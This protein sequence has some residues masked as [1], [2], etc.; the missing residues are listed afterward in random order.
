[1]RIERVELLG[2]RSFRDLQ[3]FDFS[4]HPG[5]VKLSG[6]NDD[7]PALGANGAGK[8]SFWEGVFWVLTGRTSTGLKGPEVCTWNQG[9]GIY[10]LVRISGKTLV[11]TWGTK[12]TLVLDGEEGVAQEAV[13]AWLGLT[14]EQ[15]LH[16]A[17]MAQHA[18]AFL[19]LSAAEKT[20]L[21]ASVLQLDAW[22]ELSEKARAA[23]GAVRQDRE[24]VEHAISRAEGRLRELQSTDYEALV[25]EWRNK[26][27]AVIE[28]CEEQVRRRAAAMRDAEAR[29]ARKPWED[30]DLSKDL[31]VATDAQRKQGDVHAEAVGRLAGLQEKKRLMQRGG[32][33]PTCARPLDGHE[34]RRREP[35]PTLERDIEDAEAEAARARRRFDDAR[36][37]V[38][39]LVNR[40]YALSQLKSDLKREVDDARERHAEALD[41]LSAARSE[42]SPYADL[43]ARQATQLLEVRAQ[44]ASL[45]DELELLRTHE[46]RVELWVSGFKD[47]RLFLV[48]EALAQLELEVNACLQQLGLCGWEVKFAPDRETKAGATR[49]GFSVLITSPSNPRPVPWSVW[50]GGEAQR[51]RVATAMGL[52]NLISAYTGFSPFVEVWDEPSTGMSAEGIQGLLQAFADRARLFK[53]QVWVVDHRALESGVFSQT[54]LAVKSSGSSKL[55]IV[56]NGQGE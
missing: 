21:L 30:P 45:T 40:A 22:S 10:G 32:V 46:A 44:L 8:S 7:E 33:C 12:N 54:V 43:S 9:R 34:H 42:V 2:F 4:S 56:D 41:R 13:N 18:P 29:S 28:A 37:A 14:P 20:D 6:R 1:M 50:S 16:C 25:R 15:L 51:L 49:R 52:S 36:K 35:P 24:A 53:R 19:D 27:A 23:R 55:E 3:V 47:V 11:R 31:T 38:E 48:T 17:Y 39:E 26:K 5:V